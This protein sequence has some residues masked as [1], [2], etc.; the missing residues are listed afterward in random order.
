MSFGWLIGKENQPAV[1]FV[2]DYAHMR[3]IVQMFARGPLAGPA[4]YR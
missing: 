2:A 1:V 3:A 4:A